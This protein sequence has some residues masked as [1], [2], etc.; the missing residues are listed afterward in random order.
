MPA[1]TQFRVDVTGAQRK[2]ARVKG[3]LRASD[4]RSQL[5]DYVRKVL[6]TAA[7]ITPVRDASLIRSNQ[8]T[9][10]DHRVNYIPSF[11]TLENP[12][13]IVRPDGIEWIYCDGKWYRGDWQLPDHVYAA[14]QDLQ[15]ERTRRLKTNRQEFV[16]TRSRARFLYKKSWW[17]VGQSIGINIPIGDAMRGES[18]RKPSD[19]PPKGYAQ[20]RGGKETLS[21]D[22]RNPF[23]EQPSRYKS[24]SG[25][26]ILRDAMN[27]HRN[28]FEKTLGV[29]MRGKVRSLT[30]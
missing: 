8:E 13:L 3:G 9:Q 22:I 23:L 10:Y 16:N 11:H 5:M 25:K 24:F 30:S 1:K 12:T 20:V 27:K 2:L 7:Q 18:R 6:T 29:A 28:A 14:Y 19:P 17:E 21:V 4:F 26:Q 15:S